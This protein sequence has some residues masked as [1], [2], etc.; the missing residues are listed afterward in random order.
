MS[1]I[2]IVL[3]HNTKKRLSTPNLE[4]SIIITCSLCLQR[5]AIDIHDLIHHVI[6]IFLWLPGD[7]YDQKYVEI[8]FFK[9]F[10]PSSTFGFI[11]I[12]ELAWSCHVS[13]ILFPFELRSHILF[14]LCCRASQRVPGYISHNFTP[15]IFAA[16]YFGYFLIKCLSCSFDRSF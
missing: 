8:T 1:D 10:F 11:S 9:K 7:L 3:R 12:H 15:A 13:W 16:C 2:V 4:C 14:S 5:M 6:L